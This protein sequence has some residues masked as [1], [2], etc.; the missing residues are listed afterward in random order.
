MSLSRPEKTEPKKRHGNS[1]PECKGS[2]LANARASWVAFEE[3]IGTRC[4]T[5]PTT[6]TVSPSL[7]VQYFPPQTTRWLGGVSLHHGASLFPANSLRSTPQKRFISGPTHLCVAVGKTFK[8]PRR[9][10]EKER[11]DGELK[12]VGE[13]GLRNKRE[14]WRVQ[15]A[16]SKMRQ[17]ARNLLTE[18]EV[19]SSSHSFQHSCTANLA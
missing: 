4:R 3:A 11:L 19:S 8:K 2:L 18:D 5:S 9:P 17:A 13:Y 12:L 16:L 10:F 1:P 6:E 7:S 14:L 15:M